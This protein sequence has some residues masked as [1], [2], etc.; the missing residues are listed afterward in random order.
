MG[1]AADVMGATVVSSAKRPGNVNILSTWVALTARAGN[2]RHSHPGHNQ[3]AGGS[4]A[5]CRMAPS[6]S[7]NGHDGV[8]AQMTAPA[9]VQE[10]LPIESLVSSAVGDRCVN[11]GTSL[12][13][14]QRYCVVCGE[15]RGAPRFSLPASEATSATST[16]MTVSSSPRVRGSRFGSGTTLIAGVGTLLLAL[17]VGFLI[18]NAATK[19]SGNRTITTPTKVIKINVGGG[20]TAATTPSSSSS[21]STAKHATSHKAAKKTATKTTKALA[22]KQSTAAQK[23]LGGKNTPSST[24]KVG[25]KCSGSSC[26]KPGYNS[27]T[28]KFDGSFFGGG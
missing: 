23:V 3:D 26:N 14:D 24:T 10:G 20:A 16:T 19:G 28:K 27:K 9:E 17:L 8:T 25:Q 18:G 21:G 6:P 15:R 5:V 2:G 1:S 11:C 7:E 13:S 22:K 4:Y 12:S